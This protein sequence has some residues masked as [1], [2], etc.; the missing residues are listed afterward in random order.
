MYTEK[1][2]E[3]WKAKAAKWDA[4]EAKIAACYVDDNGD[5]LE[6]EDG[7]ADLCDIGE[8]AASAFGF[9]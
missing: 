1:E 2:I 6:D 7:G 4:L 3:Q 8:I 9:L 5:E